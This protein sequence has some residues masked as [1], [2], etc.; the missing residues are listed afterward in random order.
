MPVTDFK[1]PVTA[2]LIGN[3][4]IFDNSRRACVAVWKCGDHIE[5]PLATRN[6]WSIKVDLLGRPSL[7]PSIWEKA[8]CAGNFFLQKG[9]VP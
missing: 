8:S 5:L 4:V 6:R 9:E 2:A 3:D 7:A 1:F